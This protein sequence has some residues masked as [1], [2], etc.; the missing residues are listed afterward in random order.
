MNNFIV[1]SAPVFYLTRH[2]YLPWYRVRGA[3]FPYS[4]FPPPNI[5]KPKIEVKSQ[6]QS[7]HHA[8]S[9]LF[10][11]KMKSL[12]SPKDTSDSDQ[13]SKIDRESECEQLLK[14][15][16]A[17]TVKVKNKNDGTLM[18]KISQENLPRGGRVIESHY[19]TPH[20]P[21]PEVFWKNLEQYN[22]HIVASNAN[23]GEKFRCDVVQ[24]DDDKFWEK[25]KITQKHENENFETNVVPNWF[26]L[27]MTLASF[28]YYFTPQIFPLI[29]ATFSIIIMLIGNFSKIKASFRAINEIWNS[30][31]PVT[32]NSSSLKISK[33]CRKQAR[34]DLLFKP[35]DDLIYLGK[36]KNAVSTQDMLPVAEYERFCI[37]KIENTPFPYEPVIEPVKEKFI[38]EPVQ[39]SKTVSKNILCK[40]KKNSCLNIKRSIQCQKR[41]I[42][43]KKFWIQKLA[44]FNHSA[45]FLCSFRFIRRW[46]T[47]FKNYRLWI[48]FLIKKL[49]PRL[50]LQKLLI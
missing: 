28:L 29:L 20:I 22:Q 40:K 21:S 39:K 13:Y 23:S 7:N 8:D 46:H 15:V 18:E 38:S 42:K 17:K 33:N 35:G 49:I 1:P 50:K 43:F 5:N 44:F 14:K 27:F 30:E 47:K 16:M 37:N 45:P 25:E 6:G 32:K 48:S 2:G 3:P 10:V 31:E 34:K 9:N 36:V 11:E 4:H 26:Y 12:P 19:G 41:N 24:N